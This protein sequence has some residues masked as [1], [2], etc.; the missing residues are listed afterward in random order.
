MW[1]EVFKEQYGLDQTH[2]ATIG[3]ACNLGG[4]CAI[5]AGLAYD[6]LERHR[7]K[8]PRATL[9]VGALTNAVGY[10]GLWAAATRCVSVHK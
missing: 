8:G 5:F 1:A 7:R 4:F 2:L 9:L 3:S 6:R 10:L